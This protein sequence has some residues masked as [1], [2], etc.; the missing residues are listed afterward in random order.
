L[1]WS[2]AAFAVMTAYLR[3]VGRAEG[4]GVD[5]SGPMAKPHRMAVVT[6]AALLSIAEPLWD[7]RGG[8]LEIAL[9]IVTLGA[10]ITALR[11][12]RRLVKRLRG[13]S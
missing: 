5:F 9:W 6:A 10:L 3:E 8:V 1:G 11:R 7:G 4:I 13:R 12:A 2:A